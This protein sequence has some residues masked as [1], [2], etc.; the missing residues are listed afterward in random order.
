MSQ[1]SNTCMQ[2]HVSSSLKSSQKKIKK[3]ICVGHICQ[4]SLPY[5]DSQVEKRDF[6]ATLWREICVCVCVCVCVWKKNPFQQLSWKN[7][8]CGW[9]PTKTP[10][11][12][13]TLG[14][15][16]I[17]IIITQRLLCFFFLNW[18]ELNWKISVHMSPK[19]LLKNWRTGCVNQSAKQSVVVCHTLSLPLALFKTYLAAKEEL[20]KTQIFHPCKNYII[21]PPQKKK[22]KIL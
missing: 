8:A 22:K 1:L 4:G 10:K 18:I 5:L 2:A 13:W 14:L 20:W 6:S 21:F 16:Y 3:R 12:V 7:M 15:L 11:L 9:V 19:K 17:I